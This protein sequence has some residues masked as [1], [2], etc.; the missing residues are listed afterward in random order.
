MGQQGGGDQPPTELRLEVVGRRKPPLGEVLQL[1]GDPDGASEAL[2]EAIDL[3]D[4]KEN[5]VL[6][7]AARRLLASIEAEGKMSS[8]AGT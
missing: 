1:A 2:R 8:E 3:H 5:L 7:A 6:A 4:A